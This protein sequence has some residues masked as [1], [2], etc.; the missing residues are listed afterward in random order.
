M[1]SISRLHTIVALKTV[2][3]L[4][5]ISDELCEGFMSQGILDVLFEF[6]QHVG[7][8]SISVDVSDDYVYWLVIFVLGNLAA[9]GE[10]AVESILQS[11]LFHAVNALILDPSR[12]HGLFI[13]FVYYMSNLVCSANESQVCAFGDF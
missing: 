11:P 2:S 12:N 5:P 7:T 10:N 8:H 1:N 9:G 4:V 3:N 6:L 13:E